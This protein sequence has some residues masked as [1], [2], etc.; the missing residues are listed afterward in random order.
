M[1]S[2]PEPAEPAMLAATA[3]S[4]ANELARS[5]S[6]GTPESTDVSFRGD[7]PGQL[8]PPV[9]A[10]TV[11]DIGAC[12]AGRRHRCFAVRPGRGGLR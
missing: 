1:N 4:L 7:R 11:P 8:S 12:R 5:T 9:A 6:A 10:A 2:T 3:W